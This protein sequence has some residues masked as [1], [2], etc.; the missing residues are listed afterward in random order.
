M[1]RDTFARTLRALGL[2]AAVALPFAACTQA[3]TTGKSPAFLI[4]ES[5][6]A[7]TGAEPDEED[8]VLASDVVTM[9]KTQ[10]DGQEVLVPTIYEDIGKVTFRLAL[11]DPGSTETP[12]EPSSTNFIT[13]NRYRV[14]YIR[15]DGRNTPGVDVPY[16][17]DGAITATVAGSGTKAS[18]TLVRIQAKVENPLVVIRNIAGTISTIAEVT[19]YGVDQAGNAVSVIGRIGVDFSNWGDPQ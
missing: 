7:A 5:L 2:A 16:P 8:G 3:Q 17:F 19:F 11:K 14:Q 12:N 9:I 13:V 4:I 6:T 15:A 18:F 10:V 1:R